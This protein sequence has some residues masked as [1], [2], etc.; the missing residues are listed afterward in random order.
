MGVGMEIEQ[1]LSISIELVDDHAEVFV[2]GELDAMTS[3]VLDDA[4]AALAAKKI[5][6]VIVDVREVSFVDSSG[7]MAILKGREMLHG[8]GGG[9]EVRGATGVVERV[10]DMT[11]LTELLSTDGRQ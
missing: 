3:P 7:L 6:A 2:A 5:A 8:L 4:L 1:P 9:L 11:G 10:I